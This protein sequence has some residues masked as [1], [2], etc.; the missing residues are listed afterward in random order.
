M[1]KE[2][3]ETNLMWMR[4]RILRQFQASTQKIFL[5][6]KKKIRLKKIESRVKAMENSMRYDII[7]K[8]NK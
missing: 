5:T 4:T 2:K 8:V 1:I 3:W 6:R 7:N